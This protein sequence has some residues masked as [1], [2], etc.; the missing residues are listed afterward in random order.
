MPEYAQDFD[1][2][3]LETTQRESA[4]GTQS[5]LFTSTTVLTDLIHRFTG[6]TH[7]G[8]AQGGP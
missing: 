3:G 6:T 1:T 5:L 7:L 2:E 8:P 4:V